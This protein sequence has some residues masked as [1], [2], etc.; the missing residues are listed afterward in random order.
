MWS[1]FQRYWRR[2]TLKSGVQA[3]E[4]AVSDAGDV[5]HGDDDETREC[6]GKSGPKLASVFFTRLSIDCHANCRLAVV[7]RWNVAL[8]KPWVVLDE[9]IR[10]AH[11][12]GASSANVC[13]DFGFQ[14]GLPIGVCGPVEE[15][16]Y[17]LIQ[18]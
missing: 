18:R 5:L 10:C 6:V 16:A 2:Q 8:S 3:Q 7:A 17:A 14:D 13:H 9:W 15:F 1:I 12:D 4:L 11:E